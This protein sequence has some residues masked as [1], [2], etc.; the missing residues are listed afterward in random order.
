[1]RIGREFIWTVARLKESSSRCSFSNT[2][3]DA[4]ISQSLL[5]HGSQG[6][7]VRTNDLGI[8]AQMVEW[9][10]LLPYREAP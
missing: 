7:A 3:Y 5:L 2:E 8:S 10:N 1:M 6:V 4:S 9:W